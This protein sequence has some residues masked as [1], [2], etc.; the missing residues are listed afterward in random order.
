M[1][2]VTL[3]PQFTKQLRSYIVAAY[4]KQLIAYLKLRTQPGRRAG[5][6]SHGNTCG[7]SSG[8]SQRERLMSCGSPL[9]QILPLQREVA[10]RLCAPQ[11]ALHTAG[12]S[13]AQHRAQHPPSSDLAASLGS[14]CFHTQSTIRR[15]WGTRRG[16]RGGGREMVCCEGCCGTRGVNATGR[17]RHGP[18]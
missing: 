5:R 4:Q 17:V 15:R 2:A 14:C 11:A 13:P 6:D 3:N 10:A 1:T 18:T 12:N 8:H 16:V 7:H 9:D